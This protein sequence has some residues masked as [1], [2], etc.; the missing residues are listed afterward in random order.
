MEGLTFF[1]ILIILFL[2]FSFLSSIFK[3]KKG[4]EQ[5]GPKDTKR[6]VPGEPV[7]RTP[8]P[9]PFPSTSTEPVATDEE[10]Y[11]IMKEI[12]SF[13][14][15]GDEEEKQ[16]QRE[17]ERK[18]QP[19]QYRKSE[20]ETRQT[21]SYQQAKEKAPVTYDTFSE[22]SKK[23]KAATDRKLR[24]IKNINVDTSFFEKTEGQVVSSLTADF[25]FNFKN[26]LKDKS[27][28]KEFV[29]FSEIIGKPKVLRRR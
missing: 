12:E 20:P 22:K 21:K 17:V 2:A 29:L 24:E 16:K 3:A 25:S 4:K 13:F 7:R 15:V 27:N 18:T 10:E 23:I 26:K 1:D 6:E 11:D 14:K 19:A 8:T 9:T 5:Q 28:L